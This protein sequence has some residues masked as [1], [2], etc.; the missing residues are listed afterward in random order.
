[1]SRQG[2]VNLL[3]SELCD[4]Q[5]QVIF[6]ILVITILGAVWQLVMI[7]TYDERFISFLIFTLIVDV[8][9]IIEVSAEQLVEC[10]F[11]SC[12]DLKTEFERDNIHFCSSG[13][14]FSL[15]FHSCVRR[16]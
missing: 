14:S 10:N 16:E 9:L 4:F 13:I 3:I 7:S 11:I 15:V 12:Y 5:T 2:R 1:M 8:D 6:A